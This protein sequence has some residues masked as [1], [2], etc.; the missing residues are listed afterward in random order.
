LHATLATEAGATPQLVA[1]ALGRGS[2]Q[3]A[4]MHYTDKT[5]QH[6]AKTKRV[7]GRLATPAEERCG[8]SAS[9]TTN[10][11]GVGNG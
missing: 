11:T 8:M 2:T 4:E 5:A 9:R 3:V 7:M 6:G 10:P 1:A